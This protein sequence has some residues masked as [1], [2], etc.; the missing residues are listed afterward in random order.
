MILEAGKR[1]SA[2]S[3]PIP[4]MNKILSDWKQAEVFTIDAIPQGTPKPT[5]KATQFVSA[6]VEATNAKTDRERYYALLREKAQI[7]AD[8]M[9]D[10]ANANPQFKEIA[11]KLS[12]MEIT[13]AKAEVR[14]PQDLP[15]LRKQ[16]QALLQ[17]RKDVLLTM[18][19]TEEDLL[20]KYA[21]TK[22]NDTGFTPNGTV[23]GCYKK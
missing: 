13:L 9:V 6:T 11:S 8:K 3:S 21:C 7:R 12:L 10:K 15:T 23:C 14:A 22:C 18:G 4:Y 19:L 5:P 2:S 1:S 17:Q 16:K 20:P